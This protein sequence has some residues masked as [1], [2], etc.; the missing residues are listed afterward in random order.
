VFGKKFEH[1]LKNRAE[2]EAERTTPYISYGLVRPHLENPADFPK[3]VS[4]WRGSWRDTPQ[5][6]Y[7][8][9]MSN[10]LKVYNP[11]KI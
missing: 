4:I 1:N 2:K 3:P 7:K 8:H 11:K 10:L 9:V 5:L 6:I